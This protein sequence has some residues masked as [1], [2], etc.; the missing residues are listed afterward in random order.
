MNTFMRAPCVSMMAFWRKIDAPDRADE[1]AEPRRAA[2]VERA[3]REALQ[4]GAD[5][6]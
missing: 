1:R 2:R 5:Q 4:G 3:V 6:P